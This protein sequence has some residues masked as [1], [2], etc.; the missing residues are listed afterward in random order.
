MTS[1][2]KEK[3]TSTQST[4]K[5]LA[6]IFEAIENHAKKFC[7]TGGKCL[8]EETSMKRKIVNINES[9]CNG[10]GNASL[11]AQKAHFKSL[12]EKPKSSKKP[13]ATDWAHAWDN[14]H[15]VQSQ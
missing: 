5:P 4:K 13:T 2:K 11:N 15:K 10:C 3:N 12:M 14:A 6:P 9:L 1:Q 8:K 7:P